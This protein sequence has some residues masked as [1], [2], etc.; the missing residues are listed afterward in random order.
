MEI[1]NDEFSCEYEACE[2]PDF[3][4]DEEEEGEADE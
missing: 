3:E 2:R 1:V 4:M